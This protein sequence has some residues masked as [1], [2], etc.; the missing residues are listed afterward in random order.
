MRKRPV[1]RRKRTSRL[2]RRFPWRGCAW[3][4]AFALVCVLLRL[5]VFHLVRV[6]GSSMLD[7][8][9][10]GDIVL[11]T[12]FDYRFGGTPRRGD[13]V[14]C[15]LPERVDAYIKRVVGLPGE[16]V[17]IVGGKTYIDGAPLDE[18]YV[19]SAQ[20]DYRILLGE[21][22]YLVLGDN[23]AESYDSRAED[24]GP[25]GAEDLLG[26]VRLRIWPLGG[27]S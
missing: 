25:I 3:I 27:V 12:R 2:N 26:R 8:L 22:E 17:E 18:P 6:E 20:E 1:R 4:V 9:S 19:F 10:G 15:R 16:M 5:F 21:D 14:E 23:R 7:T 13:I 24:I 11:A